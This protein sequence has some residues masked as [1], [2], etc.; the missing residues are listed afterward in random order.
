MPLTEQQKFEFLQKNELLQ[1]LSSA[2][3]KEISPLF[4]AIT[5]QANEF[6]IQEHEISDDIYLVYHGKIEIIKQ[7]PETGYAHSLLSLGQGALIGE[8]A[9][10]D[11]APRSASAYTL[12]K[13]TLLNLSIATLEEWRTH[14]D[15]TKQKI[16]FQIIQNMARHVAQRV[17]STNNAVITSLSNELL[18]T[19]ARVAM[20]MVIITV[21]IMMSVY[22]AAFNFLNYFQIDTGLGTSLLLAALSIIIVM[23]FAGVKKSGYPLGMFG[24]TCK[25]WQISVKEAVTYSIPIMLAIVGLK[26]LAIKFLSGWQSHNLFEVFS[27]KSNT[28]TIPPIIHFL[29]FFLYLFFVPFQELIARGALQSSL[30]E[31]LISPHRILLAI[32]MSNLLFASMH[33]HFSVMLTLPIF[34]LGL[35]WGWLYSR[36]RTLTGVILSHYLL[37]FWAFFIVNVMP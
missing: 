27:L 5:F 23:F 3:I 29:Q 7:D 8:L 6:I 32:L 21:C 35:F 36:H 10:L 24:I 33:T 20:G 2:E 26:W 13:T 16:Y 30:E 11:K 1:G 25:N 17:R 28:D 37:G 15:P 14:Q 18:H 12:I 19:K 22:V 4:R 9:S 34:L 31:F